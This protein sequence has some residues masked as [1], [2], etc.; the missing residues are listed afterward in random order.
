MAE[1]IA[2]KPSLEAILVLTA[3]AAGSV[4]VIAFAKLGGILCSAMT[5]NLA[6]LGF[7]IGRSAV[8][9]AIGSGIALIGYI[10]G[11]AA[12]TLISRGMDQLPALRALLGVEALLLGGAAALWHFTPHRLGSSTGD[13]VVA[14]MAISMGLQSITG[15]R[16]NLSSIPTVVFTSTL[17]NIV[18]GMTDTLAG[19]GKK[20]P[21]DTKRQ[22][23]SFLMYF[24]GALS[25]GYAVYRFWGGLIYMPVT[26]GVLAFLSLLF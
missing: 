24:T 26:A 13:G 19:K 25:T 5:G 14:L 18:I 2:K 11:S 23:A 1:R 12:G 17:T 9:S 20:L 7:Y 3:F 16:V 8:A 15:K 6:F 22:V 10:I 4:D 21:Q